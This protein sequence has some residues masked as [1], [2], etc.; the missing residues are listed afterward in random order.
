M[1][2]ECVS[3]SPLH[4]SIVFQTTPRFSSYTLHF[5]NTQSIRTMI[6]AVQVHEFAA[7]EK[8]PKGT[9]RPRQ[10]SS[11]KLREV[12]SLD[13]IP[14]PVLERQDQVV[15]ETR[16]VGIQY[17]DALQAQGLYQVRPPLPYVPSMDVTGVVVAVGSQV[18]QTAALRVGDRVVATMLQNG[19]TGGMAQVVVA[20]ASCVYKVPLN[21]HLSQC[22]NIGRNY[23]AAYHSLKTIGSVGRDS[24]VLV[25]GA[26]GGVGMATIELAKAMGATVIAAV[27]TPEKKQPPQSV[28]A[29]AVVCYGPPTKDKKQRKHNYKQFRNQVRQ[30]AKAL[31]HSQGVDLVIDMVQGSLFETL[32]SCVRPLGTIA[33]VGFTAGQTPIR[34]GLLLVKEVNVV[35]SLWGRWAL[36]YP[37]QHQQNVHEILHFLAS[38]VIQPR[39][40]RIFSLKHFADAFELFETNQGRGNTVVAFQEEQGGGSARVTIPRSRL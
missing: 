25:D 37:R 2:L 20:P 39:V 28:G 15:I 1:V 17:P 34:P 24:L 7:L 30:A 33:L 10:P 4:L 22:A 6:Q 8:G 19:G 32:L 31:G 29:D 18:K 27:S 5:N 40:D 36:E 21:L 13:S 12:L 16:Y 26:S 35:G 3:S 9:F 23:F 11:K 14:R 38:G